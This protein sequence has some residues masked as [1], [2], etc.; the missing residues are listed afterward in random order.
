[1]PRKVARNGNVQNKRKQAKI[2]TVAHLSEKLRNF[3]IEEADRADTSVSKIMAEAIEIYRKFR[4]LEAKEIQEGI[5]KPASG[6]LLEMKKEEITRK[7]DEFR[8]YSQ[9]MQLGQ[10][11]VEA[12]YTDFSDETGIAKGKCGT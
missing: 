2:P 4:I 12:R 11:S 1:M 7:E 5:K 8:L 6:R 10:D 9:S 3:L